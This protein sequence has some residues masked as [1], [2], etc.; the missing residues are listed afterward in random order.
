MEEIGSDSLVLTLDTDRLDRQAEALEARLGAVF[1]DLASDLAVRFPVRTAPVARVLG[2][3]ERQAGRL[4]SSFAALGDTMGSTVAIALTPAA[5]AMNGFLSSTLAAAGVFRSFVYS[6]LGKDTALAASETAAG[7]EAVG[8]AAQGTA[9]RVRSAAGQVRRSLM[10][11]DRINRLT[12]ASTGGSGRS[13][14]AGKNSDLRLGALV[15]RLTGNAFGEYLRSLLDD[16]RFFDFGAALAGKLGELIDG[17]SARLNAESLRTRLRSALAGLTETVNGVLA[18]LTFS[19]AD[20]RSVAG[21]LGALIGD[22]LG[23]AME[24]VHLTLTGVR[25]PKLGQAVAQFVNGALASLRARD[26]DLGTVLSDWLNTRLGSL[27]GFLAELDWAALGDTVAQNINHWFANVDWRLAGQTLRD[28]VAGL[29]EAVLSGIRGL[30][31]HWGDI[32]SAFGQGLLGEDHPGLSRL[33]FGEGV[34]VPVTGVTDE[35][36]RRKKLLGGFQALLAAWAESFAGAAR[37]KQLEFT[38]VLS[39]WRETLR[40][41]V[42]DYTA[43]LTE[44]REALAGKIVDFAARLTSWRDALGGKSLDFTARLTAWKDALRDKT[45]SFTATVSSFVGNL[46]SKLKAALGLK[47]EGGVYAGGAWRPITAYAGGGRPGGGQ[48]F[49]AREAGPEL[50]GTLGG[51]TAV[52]NNDQ[53]VASV[54]AGVARAVSGVRFFSRDAATPRLTA[55]LTASDAQNERRIAAL[56]RQNSQAG[57]RTQAT[58]LLRQI[59]EALRTMDFDVQLD[60]RS[61]KDRVV[62][63][64][65]ADTQATG[66]CALV[67]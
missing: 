66:V 31:I 57:D 13:Y 11:F 62:A 36:P 35:I 67:V 49:L 43:R 12:E 50:V 19:E 17:L 24:T 59:L 7:V 58:E 15:P 45:I 47:A 56:E 30:D 29:R 3:W 27:D 10:A 34:D 46:G 16:R 14:A 51:H 28:G 5:E 52:M 18:G 25:W 48:L 38:A 1:S 54:A 2:D 9:K 64:I 6:L 33:L 44:W 8:S 20:T 41:K 53:I 40:E 55:A 23:L 21:R 60:G 26:V 37:E 4:R 61:V 32:L 42:L 63:L 65:N 22:A 39:A